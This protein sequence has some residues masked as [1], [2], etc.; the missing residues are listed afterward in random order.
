MAGETTNESE[1][2]DHESKRVAHLITRFVE[3]LEEE[4]A[5]PGQACGAAAGVWMEAIDAV[6]IEDRHEVYLNIIKAIKPALN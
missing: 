6:P 3:I 2:A 4:E 5:T 1:A